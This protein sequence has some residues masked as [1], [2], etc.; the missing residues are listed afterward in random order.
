MSIEQAVLHNRATTRGRYL[1][2]NAG[3]TTLKRAVDISGAISLLILFAPLFLILA[4]AISIM[5]GPGPII[6][7][8]ERIGRAGRRF[9]CLKFRTMRSDAEDALCELLAQDPHTQA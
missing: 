8:Q 2:K 1:N 7:R 4:L 9:L 3:L 5:G 6:Y